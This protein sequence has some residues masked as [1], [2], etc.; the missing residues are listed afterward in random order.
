MAN[1]HIHTKAKPGKS[2]LWAANCLSL[3]LLSACT[4]EVE[5]EALVQEP[6]GHIVV[7]GRIAAGEGALIV[8]TRPASLA[9]PELFPPVTDAKAVLSDN[10]G[11]QEQLL[12]LGHGHYRS[13]GIQ[14]VPGA[15]YTLDI[16]AGEEKVVGFSSMPAFPIVVDSALHM[17]SRDEAGL[18]RSQILLYFHD[19][20]GQADFAWIRLTTSVNGQQH[21]YYFFY[22]DGAENGQ[23]IEW[24]LPLDQLLF[25][26]QTARVEF[27]QVEEEVY[28]LFENL[29]TQQLPGTEEVFL[30]PPGNFSANLQDN[31]PGYFAAV[32]RSEE[33]VIVQ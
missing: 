22:K 25:H 7:E 33:L 15:Q 31:A 14:G 2:R 4:Q 17:Q 21:K 5:L 16:E 27:F 32:V 28:H 19:P 20:P 1:N 30:A 12:H 24:P 11:N 8:L 6:P 10:Y 18:L 23:Y 26:G 13:Y 9:Y 29:L 3:L